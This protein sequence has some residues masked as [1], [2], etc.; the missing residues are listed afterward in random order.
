MLKP[1]HEEEATEAYFR[2]LDAGCTIDRNK[3]GKGLLFL[4]E[5]KDA[6][7]AQVNGEPDP[8]W[9]WCKRGQ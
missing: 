1:G 7:R 4:L 3:P 8:G 6:L 2:L 5:V 9:V